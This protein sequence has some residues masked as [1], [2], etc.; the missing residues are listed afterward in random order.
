MMASVHKEVVVTSD[1]TLIVRGLPQFAGHAVEV[2][3]RDKQPSVTR[4][5]PDP[6]RNSVLRFDRPFDPV[7]DMDWEA[8]R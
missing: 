1:G 5:E 2:V 4:E 3:V 8:A 6:L 7:S